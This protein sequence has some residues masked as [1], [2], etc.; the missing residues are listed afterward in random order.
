MLQSLRRPILAA[1]GVAIAVGGCLTAV[2]VSADP[3]TSS[4][5]YSGCITNIGGIIYDVHVNATTLP[6]CG[7]NKPITFN[8]TGPQGVPGPSGPAGATG[9]AGPPGATG[10][11]GMDG[12]DGATGAAGPAGPQGPTGATGAV[13]PAGP[14][15]PTGATGA[16]GAAGPAGTAAQ[17][18]TN[19]LGF[20]QGEGGTVPCTIGSIMLNAGTEYPSNYMSAAGQTLNISEN[21]ALFSLIGTNYGGNGTTTFQLPDL[22]SAA[23][24]NT[25]YLICVSGV[26]P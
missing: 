10:A 24:D 17:F 22:T 2:A 15:G 19:T 12:T 23:P 25:I 4:D 14:Q 1:V 11:P 3:G 5:V 20:F 8:A 9:P 6:R 21:P 7:H 26:F 13:G 18:G 16:T